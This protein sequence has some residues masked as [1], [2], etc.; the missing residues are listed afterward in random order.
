MHNSFTI[1]IPSYNVE[2]WASKNVLS[3]INQEYKNYKIF[4]ID[5]SS[6]DKTAELVQ[7]HLKQTM[8]NSQYKFVK[9]SFNKGKMENV[10]ESVNDSFIPDEDIVIILD[11]DDWLANEHVLSKLNSL[12]GNDNNVWMTAGSYVEST[13]NRVITPKIHSDYWIGNLR[14]KS[15]QASH[16]VS[17]RKKLFKK[18]KRKHFMKK[19]GEYFSTTSDQAMVWPMLEMAG[20]E[21][22]KVV[23]DVLYVYNRENPLSDDRAFRIDQLQ[24]ENLIRNM[25]PYEKLQDL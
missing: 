25:I 20:K 8:N 16:L 11:G 17:F 22:F 7:N 3:A 2:K 14:K 21:N 1:L 13:T 10:V 24:T 12:Y 23:E 6:T 18:I 9:N 15:W 5:D 4:Y 19:T